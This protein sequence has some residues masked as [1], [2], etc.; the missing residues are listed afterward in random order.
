VTLDASKSTGTGNLSFLWQAVAYPIGFAPLF[1][2]ST[3]GN[4]PVEQ[5]TPAAAGD[6]SFRVT[7]TDST[8][9]SASAFVLVTVTGGGGCGCGSGGSGV[10][11]ALMLAGIALCLRSRKRR[12]GQGISTD[13]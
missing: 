9:A 1:G 5:V 8:K 3:T 12:S 4:I 7:V 6:Y 13:G 11:V 2:T 10:G